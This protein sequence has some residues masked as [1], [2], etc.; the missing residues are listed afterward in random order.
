[1][2]AYLWHYKL[3][4]EPRFIAEQGHW[5]QRPGQATVEVIGPRDD[6]QTVKV[7][8]GAVTIFQGNMTI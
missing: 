6:I 8:G 2:A 3:I 1:M 5:M 7:G 4:K